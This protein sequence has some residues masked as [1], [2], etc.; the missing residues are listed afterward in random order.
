MP[1]LKLFEIIENLFGFVDDEQQYHYKSDQSKRKLSETTD[2]CINCVNKNISHPSAPS[3]DFSIVSLL[4]VFIL[5][6]V[7]RIYS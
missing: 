7:F 5:Y 4:L 1:L 2:I 3:L 6:F